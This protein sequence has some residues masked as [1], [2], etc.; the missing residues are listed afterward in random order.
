MATIPRITSITISSSNTIWDKGQSNAITISCESAQSGIT[1]FK[2]YI[3]GELKDTFNLTIG[4]IGGSGDTRN[5]TINESGYHTIQ[6]YN[7]YNNIWSNTLIINIKLPTEL[8]NALLEL[9]DNIIGKLQKYNINGLTVEGLTTLVNKFNFIPSLDSI[10]YIVSNT[11]ELINALQNVKKSETIVLKSGTYTLSQTY[12]LPAC[13]L[14]GQSGTTI[15]GYG[16]RF[17]QD[18]SL[19]YVNNITFDCDGNTIADGYGFICL[20]N[21][22]HSYITNCNF[23]NVKAQYNPVSI[24]ISKTSP[25][26]NILISNNNFTGTATNTV[27]NYGSTGAGI[28]AWANTNFYN[29]NIYNNTFNRS[30]DTSLYA[31]RISGTGIAF[32]NDSEGKNNFTLHNCKIY[33][34]Q[35]IGSRNFNGIGV[36]EYECDGVTP[37]N[38]VNTKV[39]NVVR[40]GSTLRGEIQT[41]NNIPVT[42]GIVDIVIYDLSTSSMLI[43]DNKYCREQVTINNG[44]FISNF[45]MNDVAQ[46]FNGNLESCIIAIEYSGGVTYNPCVNNYY[47]YTNIPEIKLTLN[48]SPSTIN[49]NNN[50]VT[51]SGDIPIG[52]VPIKI[53]DNDTYI[54]STNSN[55]SGNYSTS[56]TQTFS[57]GT[58]RIKAVFEGNNDY[59]ASE[60]TKNLTVNDTKESQFTNIT[61]NN[62]YKTISGYLKTKC[63]TPIV[64]SSI[65]NIEIEYKNVRITAVNNNTGQTVN[66]NP[67]QEGTIIISGATTDNNGYI[68]NYGIY[69]ELAKQNINVTSVEPKQIIMR[70]IGN[71]N[72]NACEQVIYNET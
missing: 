41:T 1:E 46:A 25:M 59:S 65:D 11:S 47:Y 21:N 9:Q 69:T 32:F 49:C 53:Y 28:G 18:G 12:D 16:L 2:T 39:T 19:N 20:N 68:N 48:L 61:T 63:G 67:N 60:V 54:L 42:N 50:T 71:S 70:F 10:K 43:I 52:S 64:V 55:S 13:N 62:G 57:V 15:N 34:N 4:S 17:N 38:R 45:N 36:V 3:D 8:N 23:G 22:A 51:M 29:V 33:C 24:R 58:H 40:Q 44:K 7:E 66:V 37:K 14:I 56:I 6:L 72:Y 30:T 31:I 5:Y 27:S 35:Y 26:Y